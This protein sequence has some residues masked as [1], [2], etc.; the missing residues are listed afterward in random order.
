[1][2]VGSTAVP[3]VAALA[4]GMFALVTSDIR[5]LGDSLGV[6]RLGLVTVASVVA[7][8]LTTV[9]GAGLWER[10]PPAAA[11]PVHRR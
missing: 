11:V 9:V 6:V 4:A 7:L 3:L 5:R 8:V 2:A 1:M 10:A